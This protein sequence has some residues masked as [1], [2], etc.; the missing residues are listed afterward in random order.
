MNVQRIRLIV[1]CIFFII[2]IYGGLLYIDLGNRLPTFSCAYVDDKGGGCFLVGFQHMLARPFAE[3]WGDAGVRLLKAVGIFS[4]WAIVLNKAWC[5]WVCPFGL[6][7][8]LLTK[9][10]NLV[11]VD[12][13]RFAWMTR[14][15]YK[16]VKYILLAL[17][18]LIPLGIGNALPGLSPLSRDWSA[19][20]CQMCPARVLLP[21]FNGDL[22]EIYI[23]FSNGPGMLLTT[24]AIL[25]TGLFFTAAFVKR[26]FL[27][28]YC[29]M[30]ALLSF[31]DKIGFTSLKKEGQ[32][33]T[34]CGNCSRACPMEIRE[35]E[36]EKRLT[37]L[38]TQDCILCLRCVEVCPEDETLKAEFLGL[39]LFGATEQGF[40]KRQGGGVKAAND[41]EAGHE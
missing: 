4:L 28:A 23:D 35:I 30:L 21:V 41:R 7:Q 10:R 11:S 19:P 5:G 6:I 17:L 1:Q 34:R 29:P 36:T 8:D 25:L 9:L 15:R 37:N 3:F 38:V 2:L 40:R 18:I 12:L 33:C 39:P 14:K 26:R 32:R 31:F 13:S 16:S 20:F 24:L 27:C 22:S